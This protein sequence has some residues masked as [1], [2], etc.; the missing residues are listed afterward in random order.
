MWAP[1]CCYAVGGERETRSLVLDQVLQQTSFAGK[2]GASFLSSAPGLRD[3]DVIAERRGAAGVAAPIRE[4]TR[5]PPAGSLYPAIVYQVKEG[6]R[7]PL[8]EVSTA[9]SKFLNSLSRVV[10]QH[11]SLRKS[12]TP[13]VCYLRPGSVQTLHSD[14]SLQL[15][16]HICMRAIISSRGMYGEWT[17]TLSLSV[18]VH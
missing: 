4:S 2:Q 12:A 10:F 9:P 13:H 14:L 15:E 17:A 3:T 11:E 8:S 5:I 18:A 16:K 6:E 7:P 1:S